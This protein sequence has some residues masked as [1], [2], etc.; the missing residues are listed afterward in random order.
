[1]N[2]NKKKL[3]GSFGK[4]WTHTHIGTIKK[5][6]EKYKWNTHTHRLIENKIMMTKQTS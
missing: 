6:K 3:F 4:K 1:M 5:G 2:Q